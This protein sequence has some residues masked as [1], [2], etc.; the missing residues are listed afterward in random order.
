MPAGLRRSRVLLTQASKATLGRPALAKVFVCA[1]GAT[2]YLCSSS[3]AASH[4]KSDVVTHTEKAVANVVLKESKSA[5]L[6]FRGKTRSQT[7]GLGTVSIRGQ[8]NGTELVASFT[9]RYARGQIKGVARIAGRLSSDGRIKFKGT[10][11]VTG[12]TG[13]YTRA[14]GRGTVRGTGPLDFSRATLR[15][16][17]V[18]SY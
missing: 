8:L 10:V 17:G 4:P 9:A 2:A 12:G 11:R 18:V 7:F 3:E 1:L 5:S 15:Q 16:K 6:L 13:R 14:H